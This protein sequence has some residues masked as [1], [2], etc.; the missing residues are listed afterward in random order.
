MALMTGLLNGALE[1]GR[2]SRISPL[3]LALPLLLSVLLIGC[4]TP[5]GPPPP[6][7]EAAVP[8]ETKEDVITLSGPGQLLPVV[9]TAEIKGETFQ[10]EVAQTRQEQALGLMFRSEL[11]TDRGMLFPFS[12]P[13]RTNFWMKDVPVPLD[14]V[15]LR[16]GEVV[17]IAA[18][19]APCAA[20]PC[21]TYG[22]TE[23]IVDQVLELRG[24]RAAELGLEVGDR[25]DI[26]A[27][28]EPS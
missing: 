22:P 16:N 3:P 7:E 20:E 9:A 19:A 13:R 21:P 23:E 4:S 1:G 18:E 10:L 12:T 6:G 17:Y 8:T 27:I 25:V 15:F 14:M 2:R 28:T 5:D 26:T 11:P 24:G